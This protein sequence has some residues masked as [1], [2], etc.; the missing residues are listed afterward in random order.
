MKDLEEESLE[1]EIVGE[2]LVDLKKKF[3][4]EDDKTMKIVE[5]K[6]VEQVSKVME[7]YVQEFRRAVRESEYKERPLVEEF[8]R[9][10][11]RMI[12]RKL[13]KVERSSRSI[14]Q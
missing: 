7:E 1:Y 9:R 11:N 5:L 10:I 13:I 12:G 2:F 14:N 3:G 8:K 4:R 6:K